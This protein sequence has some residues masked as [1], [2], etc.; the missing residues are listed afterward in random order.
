L[1]VQTRSGSLIGWDAGAFR[2]SGSHSQARENKSRPA[3]RRNAYLRFP[4]CLRV[5]DFVIVVALGFVA[6]QLKRGYAGPIALVDWLEIAL[7][8]VLLANIFALSGSYG[9]ETMRHVG[10]QLAR[11]TLGWII[12]IVTLVALTYGL[13]TDSN[14]TRYWMLLWFLVTLPALLVVRVVSALAIDRWYQRGQLAYRVAIVGNGPQSF[15]LQR[16]LR[17]LDSRDVD[18]VGLFHVEQWPGTASGTIDELCDLANAKLLDEIVISVP[19]QSARDI[20]ST[21]GKLSTL[22]ID[23]KLYSGAPETVLRNMKSALDAPTLIVQRQPLTGWNASLKRTEDMILAGVLLIAFSPLFLLIAA[24]IK[25]DSPGP[26]LFRQDRFGFLNNNLRIYKFRTMQHDPFPDPRVPQATRDDARVTRVGAFLRRT[27]LD[28]LPQLFNVLLGTMSLVGPRPHAAAHNKKYARLIDGYLGR[29]RMKPGITGWAQVHGHRG[30][31]DTIDK[32]RLRLEHDLYYI[33]NWSLMLD[34][35]ILMR[36][37]P[38]VILGR[39]AY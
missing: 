4:G 17:A 9:L 28:E 38:V 34:L 15:Q 25:V 6:A 36:T 27:S 23:L 29:H 24:I 20:N 5:A 32:M 7:G 8:G 14:L 16:R 3:S 12:V 19:W 22:P 11:A 13:H 33:E 10:A 21:I 2:H 35:Q 39:N 18:V 1:A 30:E 37:F 31:T 26:V